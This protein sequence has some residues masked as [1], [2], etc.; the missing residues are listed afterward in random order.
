MLTRKRLQRDV[1]QIQLQFSLSLWV[2]SSFFYS[3]CDAQKRLFDDLPNAWQAHAIL[4]KADRNFLI[5]KMNIFI[6]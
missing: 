1:M 3:D 6:V 2:S 5:A 4:N